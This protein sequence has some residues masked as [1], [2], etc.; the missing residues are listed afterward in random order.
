MFTVG[1]STRSLDDVIALVHTH[2]VEAIVDVRRM[3]R[4]G[5][6]PQFNI[7]TMPSALAA[8]GIAYAHAPGLGGLRR[9]RPD[10]VN[11]GWRNTS[12]RA[13]ADYMQTPEFA[14]ALDELL[15]R[16]AATPLAAM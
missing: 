10:S 6:H 11:R 16:A 15:R 5:R 8:A 4:S 7:D 9:G 3:P 2:G 13:Y 1:H 12:F 14:L